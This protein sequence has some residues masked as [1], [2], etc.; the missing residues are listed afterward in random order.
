M[1]LN[2]SRT[3][4]DASPSVLVP[5]GREPGNFGDFPVL[6][7]IQPALA[8][9]FCRR[10]GGGGFRARRGHQTPRRG[11]AIPR[12]CGTPESRGGRCPIQLCRGG[13]AAP[14]ARV[15]HVLSYHLRGWDAI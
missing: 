4:A 5:A 9:G 7:V 2:I 15:R 1:R 14:K 10:G 11:R 3:R 8:S 12:K 6:T 13:A